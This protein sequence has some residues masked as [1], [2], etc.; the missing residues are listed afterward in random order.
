[1]IQLDGGNLGAPISVFGVGFE[2]GGTGTFVTGHLSAVPEPA[3]GLL[4]LLGLAEVIGW[5]GWRRG[6]GVGSR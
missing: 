6:N 3:S 1:M 2:T 5:R 4:L